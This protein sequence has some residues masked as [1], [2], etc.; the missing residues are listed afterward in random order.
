[1]VGYVKQ[2]GNTDTKL[3]SEDSYVSEHAK[4][5]RNIR[6]RMLASM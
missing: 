3:I 2:G 6:T 1:M 4:D 5:Y